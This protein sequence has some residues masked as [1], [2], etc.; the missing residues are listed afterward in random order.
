MIVAAIWLLLSDIA[1]S[2]N[3][4]P[5]PL[6]LIKKVE[7]NLKLSSCFR[8]SLQLRREY[9]YV[10][11]QDGFQQRFDRNRIEFWIGEANS[12]NRKPGLFISFLRLPSLDDSNFK[13]VTGV[14]DVAKGHV[15][16]GGCFS[17]L[18]H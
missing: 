14:Y 13:F 8:R 9:S 10:G 2:N 5:P 1:T 3:K 11:W 4:Q 12:S 15:T 6:A 17:N 16:S 18:S 7:A